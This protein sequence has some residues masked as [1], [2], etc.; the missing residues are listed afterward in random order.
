MSSSRSSGH[1]IEFDGPTDADVFRQAAEW[2]T[3]AGDSVYLSGVNYSM[4][5]DT[6]HSIL[7][8]YFGD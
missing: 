6:H 2:L 3:Q 1:S 5:E 4:A 8:L 7:D